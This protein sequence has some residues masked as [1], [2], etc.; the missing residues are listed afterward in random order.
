MGEA[1]SAP[2]ELHIRSTRTLKGDGYRIENLVYETRPGL[3]V[4]QN[5]HTWDA[6]RSTLLADVPD[7]PLPA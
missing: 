3:L 7:T 1:E 6:V 4:A 2:A 5:Q